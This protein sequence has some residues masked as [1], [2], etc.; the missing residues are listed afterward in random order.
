MGSVKEEGTANNLE[1]E[2]IVIYL[3]GAA[4]AFACIKFLNGCNSSTLLDCIDRGNAVCI[5]ADAWRSK[6]YSSRRRQQR[7]INAKI[8]A[9]IKQQLQLEQQRARQTRAISVQD[10]F[11][12][13]RHHSSFTVHTLPVMVTCTRTVLSSCNMTSAEE[14]EN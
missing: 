2:F 7:H 5:L 9:G 8:S 14:I 10:L 11:E 3:S 13:V 4:T 6:Y 1:F 12:P